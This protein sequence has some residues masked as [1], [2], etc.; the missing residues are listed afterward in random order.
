[1]KGKCSSCN[2][3]TELSSVSE[4]SGRQYCW[5]LK[6]CDRNRLGIIDVQC[7]VVL[8]CKGA[9][10]YFLRE[11]YSTNPHTKQTFFIGY[12]AVQDWDNATTFK[13]EKALELADIWGGIVVPKLQ[14]PSDTKPGIKANRIASEIQVS[15]K[16]PRRIGARPFQ[17]WSDKLRK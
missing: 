13:G 14:F 15:L 9:W 3:I 2:H 17:K 10:K 6:Q 8:R 1:M 16:N 5:D 7:W 12:E 4:G 11:A